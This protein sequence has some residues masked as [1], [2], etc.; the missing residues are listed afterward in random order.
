MNVFIRKLK[1]QHFD[2]SKWALVFSLLIV[3]FIN[4]HYKIWDQENRVIGH[5]TR[6]YYAYLPA[7]FIY[8]DLSLEFL[9]NGGGDKLGKGFWGTKSPTGHTVIITS[10]GMS[11]LYSPFFLVSHLI[12]INTGYPP[13]G[14]TKPYLYGLLFSCFFYL[15]LG[16]FF[17][18]KFLLRYF[19]KIIVGMT[20]IIAV[21]STNMLWYATFEATMSHV[22]SFALISLFIFLLD[23]WID[24]PSLKVTLVIG[25]LLGIISLVRPTNLSIVILILLWKV[26]NL[27]DLGLRFTFILKNWYLVFI[28]LIMF[29][30]IW[31]PQF[32]YWKFISGNYLFYSYPESMGFFFN[33][34]QLFNTM[35]SWRK[36]LL[37]YTPVMVFFMIGIVMLYKNKRE[38]FWPVLI[39]FLVN[40]YVIS[41]W[42][43]WWYGGGLSMRPFID[44]YG[45]YSI[46]MAT[47]LTWTLKT[48]KIKK[49]TLLSLIVVFSTLGFWNFK[50]YYGGSI[51]WAY[52]TKEAYLDS[53]WQQYPTAEFYQKIRKPDYKLAKKGIYK[54]EDE[55]QDVN[56]N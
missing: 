26:K 54:Y 11:L 34:P 17:L 28:I 29:F 21:L 25:L 16:L 19:S 44:Y 35:L 12:A 47:L 5:D 56:L 36:G 40:W 41:S 52:M 2:F 55:N 7:T 13:N 27:N 38:F 30:I 32:L 14:Y 51:H 8:H 1:A 18:R 22:Y 48:G 3:L 10:Y 23:K 43:D 37:I 31:I 6:S 4:F 45:V 46:G 42:W 39:Y 20:I 33:N 24:N 53:F 49:I 50:K 9:K 15:A